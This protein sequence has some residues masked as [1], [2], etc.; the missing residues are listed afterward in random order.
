MW[1]RFHKEYENPNPQKLFMKILPSYLKFASLES[2]MSATDTWNIRVHL[3]HAWSNLS[4]IWGKIA[5]VLFY[6]FI[7]AIILS[8]VVTIFVPSSQGVQCFLDS[9][10]EWSATLYVGMLRAF[11][12]F[13]IGFLLYADT[14]GLHSKNV[15][16]VAATTILTCSFFIKNAY[17][18]KTTQAAKYEL[19]EEC[20]GLYI[21]GSCFW[22]AWILVTLI[23]TMMEERFGDH[24]TDDERR[25]LSA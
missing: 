24:G 22:I 9:M 18:L 3:E 8:S 2:T 10:D 5:L 20:F 14:V 25:P 4:T 16:F 21:Y 19:H 23:F 11:N 7:W 15:A 17:D 6:L 12:I 13:F 1:F